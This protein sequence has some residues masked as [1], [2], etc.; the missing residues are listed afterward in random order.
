MQTTTFGRT[1]LVVSRLGFGAAPIGF[2]AEEQAGID[3]VLAFLVDSGVNLI[4]TAAAYPGSE[5]AIGK[6]LAHRRDDLV[7]VS[8][9]GQAFDDLPGEAWSPRVITATVDRSLRRLQTD[10]LDVMLLHSCSLDVLKRGDALAAL[11]EARD[12]GKVRHVGYSGD[13]DAA[14]WA[15][16][17]P[18]VAVIETSV[19]IVDQRNIDAVLPVCL[20]HDVGV[21]AKRPIANAAWKDLSLQRGMYQK[22]AADYTAR[23]AAMKVTPLELGYSGHP[24]VEWPEIALKF[25]LAQPGVHTAIVGTTSVNSAKINIQA[26]AKNALR[27]QVVNRLRDAFRQAETASGKPWPGLT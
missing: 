7:L 21:I 14:A 5:E 23:L 1:G 8:K 9:C 12:A 2:L 18:D 24:D 15:A 11:L 10:R 17:Q 27:E 19:N 6:A 4:D 3:R 13:N 25:T 16:A 26:V 20:E 22:Y